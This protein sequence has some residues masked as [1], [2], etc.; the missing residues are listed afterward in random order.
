MEICRSCLN[1][2]PNK[3]KLK[4]HEEYCFKNEM[5]KIEMPK[6][7]SSISFK[8]H[9]RSIKVPF[10]FYADFEA[11][12]EVVSTC[13]PNDKF[14]FTKQYQKHQPSGFCYKCVGFNTKKSVLYRGENVPQKFVEMLERDIKTI[15]KKFDFSKKM[16]PLTEKEQYEFEKAKIRWIC[17]KEF[18]SDKKVKDHCHFTGKFRGAAHNI[19]NMHF[20]KPKF[21]PVIIHN[22]SRYD[23]HLF[24]KNLGKTEGNIKCI[25]NNEEKYLSFS[26]DI[27]VDE[28]INKKGKKVEVKHEIRFIDSFKFMASSLASLVENLA[29]SDLSKF[30]HTKKEFGKK[31]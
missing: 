17:Q 8:H 2:F 11:F 31:I 28:Y 19:C 29:K 6:E 9:N 10:V 3:K 1:H 23:S 25:P 30:I 14:S 26:K 16:L 15:Y 18:G 5:V 7:G 22:L 20:R 27:V 24:V 4:I 13:E 12:T 21:T